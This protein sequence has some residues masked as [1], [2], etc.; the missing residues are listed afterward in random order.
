MFSLVL[1]VVALVGEE[2]AM[3]ED[4][5]FATLDP[6][7]RRVR[8]REGQTVIV[9]DTVGFI[10]KLPT[11]LVA[12]FRATLEEVAEADLLVHVVDVTH[13]DAVLQAET[14]ERVLAELGIP[15]RIGYE[16]LVGSADG[17]PV[18]GGEEDFIENDMVSNAVIKAQKKVE[19][20]IR[21]DFYARSGQEWIETYRT[22]HGQR[23]R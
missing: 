22:Y 3:V 7:T 17:V 6:T 11:Q 16:H 23:F 2:A 9:S 5:L 20:R 4:M 21:D 15:V 14:V 19:K 18:E 1:F 10:Q 13:P 12:A 8:L